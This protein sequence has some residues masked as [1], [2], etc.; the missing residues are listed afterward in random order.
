VD[1]ASDIK[2]V[3]CDVKRPERGLLVLE[4]T[5][6]Q[7]PEPEW[8]DFLN[9]SGAS[10]SGSIGYA[11][12]RGAKL[13]MH[14]EDHDIEL[15]GNYIMKSIPIANQRFESEVLA[16]RRHE[17]TERLA[18]EAAIEASLQEARARLRNASNLND[19]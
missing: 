10:K 13:L 8:L 11:K 17:S 18:Q 19:E 9:H 5:L 6:N 15:A 1:E 2:L 12:L 3:S 14:V 7:R 4:W 16:K